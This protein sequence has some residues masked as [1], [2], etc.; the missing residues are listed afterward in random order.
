MQ[1]KEHFEIP[2]RYKHVSL[3]FD[4]VGFLC[5][6]ILYFMALR[7]DEAHRARFWASLLQNSVYFLLMVNAAMFF[8]CATTLAWEDSRYLSASYRGYFS[9]CACFYWHDYVYN[10]D[11]FV[12]GGN[13][14]Y[15]SMAR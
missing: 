13:T 7:S 12:F 3:C 4:G 6:I 9:M 2:R 10:F 11:G 15:L 8:I 1:L 14:C 5:I